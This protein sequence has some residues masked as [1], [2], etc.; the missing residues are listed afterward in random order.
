ML[1]HSK[2]EEHLARAARYF[3]GGVG[4]NSRL[5]RGIGP[6]CFER[7]A[8]SRIFDLDGN[9][10]IDYI[11]ALGP[12]LL[13]HCP[14]PVVEAVR[15][16]LE[17]GTIFG[18]AA[19]GE[20][21]LAESVCQALPSVELVRF[22]NSSSEAVHM[23][24]RLAK[25]FT[26]R[27]KILK[28][29]G[30]YHGWIEDIN[31]SVRPKPGSDMGLP[32]APN[33][34]P[35]SPG[36]SRRILKDVL[37]APFNRPEAVEEIFARHGHEIAALIL[38]PIPA[39]NGVM[40]PQEGFLE[41]LRRLTRQHSSLLIFDET[42]T[43]FRVGLGGA[44][45]YYNVLPDLTVFGKGLGGGYPIAGFG[46]TRE[47]MELIAQ[48]KIPHGGTYNSNSL[49]VA[50]ANA[51]MAELRRDGGAVFERMTALGKQL[52]DGLREV[53]SRHGIPV[54]TQGPG[55]FFSAYL[56][57]APIET[58]RDVFVL[59]DELYQ[60]F[61]IGLLEQGVRILGTSRALWLL[62]AA[63]TAEDVETTLERVDEVAAAL[64]KP[65]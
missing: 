35:E 9:E 33:P 25:A 18:S 30:G 20:E 60:R 44:Q 42:I 41:T 26:S 24:L 31:V 27:T 22:S 39:N 3:A 28:F 10:Y 14:A 21:Q 59:D 49:C 29:E 56:T 57:E 37:I 5:T 19:A 61:W 53:F 40:P 34:L 45:E 15:K 13:G 23:A 12:L 52:M 50:A 1:N 43:G 8:G 6:I 48:K 65:F 4:S 2:S 63:H 58:Y 32:E 7:G 55:P 46:G 11:L 36:Q 17:K 38:E 16:Q 64:G 62:S 51:V 47:I 54:T